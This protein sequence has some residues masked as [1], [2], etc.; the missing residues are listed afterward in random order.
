MASVNIVKLLLL[1]KTMANNHIHPN[2]S[3]K[4]LIVHAP[5]SSGRRGRYVQLFGDLVRSAVIVLLGCI[6]I[7][8]MTA[9]TV[10][11]CRAILWAF[12]LVLHALKGY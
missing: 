8:A 4:P 9:V 11:A 7:S 3:D 5:S 6:V 12:Q 10:C 2:D 1:S